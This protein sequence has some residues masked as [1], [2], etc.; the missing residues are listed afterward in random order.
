VVGRV[1]SALGVQVKLA[2]LRRRRFNHL[3]NF[4]KRLLS[5][6]LDGGG[7]VVQVA[8][9]ASEVNRLRLLR[10]YIHNC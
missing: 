4:F 7:E 8:G 5:D 10:R 9:N 1:L 2:F 6:G 3:H